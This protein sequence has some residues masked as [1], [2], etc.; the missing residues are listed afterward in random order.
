MKRVLIL[1]ILFGLFYLLPTHVSANPVDTAQWHNMADNYDYPPPKTAVKK[2]KED[3]QSDKDKPKKR[4]KS[5]SFDLSPLQILLYIGIAVLFIGLIV[6]LTKKGYFDF[7]AKNIELRTEHDVE[8]PEELVASELENKLSQASSDG[9]YNRCLRYQFLL[10]L[11]KFQALN[12]ITWHKYNTNGDY[13]N[14]LMSHEH[15]KSI[16]ELT[17]V[18]E[19]YWYGEYLLSQQNYEKLI[20]HFDQ[21]KTNLN[22]E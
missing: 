12:L 9:N 17:L 8:N 1:S 3:S 13:L 7:G 18:Y 21:L 5:R 22:N 4:K 14:Q 10:M 16:Q 11:E 2:P 15:Y 19:Y 6:V 20:V